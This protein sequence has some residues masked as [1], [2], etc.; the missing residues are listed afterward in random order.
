[1]TRE[2][3]FVADIVTLDASTG[4]LTVKGAKGRPLDLKVKDPSVL[5]GY[6]AGDQIEGTFTQVLSIKDVGPAPRRSRTRGSLSSATIDGFLMEDALGRIGR[7]TMSLLAGVSVLT[8]L[9]AGCATSLPS[10]EGRR[11]STAL[12][13]TTGTRLGR[14]LSDEVAAHPGKTAVHP[15]GKPRDAFAARA[16]L[17]AAAERSLD[18]QYYIWHDDPVGYLLFEA[19][20][21]AA[22]R[23]VQVRLLLDDNNTGG[24]DPTLAAL[25]AHPNIEV[26]L[27]NPFAQRKMRSLGYLTDFSRLNRRMHNKSFTVDNQLTIVGGRNIGDEYFGV[28]SGVVFADLDL[29]VAGAAVGQVSREFDLYWNSPSAYPAASVIGPPGPNAAAE[30]Q[31]RFATARADKES[32]AYLEA[33]RQTPVLRELIDRQLAFVWAPA[34]VLYDDPA[35]T[36]EK[37]PSKDVLLFPALVQ[38]MGR[39]Q[40]SLDLISPY[41]VPGEEGTTALAGLAR[42]GVQ[43][44]ILTNS[45]AASDVSAVHSGY[46]KR[47]LDLLQAG[48]RLYELKP[49]ANKDASADSGGFGSSS[50]SG[51]HAKTFAV[52]RE[53]I[54]VGSF[55]FDMR[56]ALLNTEMGLVVDS[57]E[58]ALQ[59]AEGFDRAVPLV[60]Y[61]VVLGPDGKTLQWIER[62]AAGEKVYDTEPETGLFKR[63]GVDVMSILPIEWLL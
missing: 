7:R 6:Q 27:Y 22:E 63:I 13:D 30:L 58:L 51:L 53:R 10:L 25:D 39:P 57:P 46:A 24:L 55:N 5:K 21:Q 16:V 31:A 45:L 38:A 11:A 1:V 61:Q 52:D 14:A 56:S 34:R 49:S 29:L 19:V 9:L 4:A 50:S 37:K 47:R 17:A 33:V 32:V 62:T 42:N 12:A 18:L 8:S 60:A 23:G 59:M 41:F 48:V 36:V 54:F 40:K 2:V 28:G 26:R 20:W 35:K 15:L 3:N 43:V 44:R